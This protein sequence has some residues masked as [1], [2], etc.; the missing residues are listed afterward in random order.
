MNLPADAADILITKMRTRIFVE[1]KNLVKKDLGE[2]CSSLS[3]PSCHF[4]RVGGNTKK[5]SRETTLVGGVIPDHYISDSPG[6]DALAAAMPYDVWEFDPTSLPDLLLPPPVEKYE[7]KML[8]LKQQ[9]VGRRV[10]SGF[11]QGLPDGVVASWQG[12]WLVDDSYRAEKGTS[13]PT[14][15]RFS[16]PVLAR[17]IWIELDSPIPE[18]T[19]NVKGEKE[20]EKV[21]K[22]RRKQQ[23]AIVILRRGT[24]TVWSSR[25]LIGSTTVDVLSHGLFGHAPLSPVDEIVVL[26]RGAGV[27]V[28]AIELDEPG[29][30][31]V[32]LML[33][34]KMPVPE[35]GLVLKH[36]MVDSVLLRK[37]QLTSLHDAISG[38]YELEFG[39]STGGPLTVAETVLGDESKSIITSHLLKLLA[40]NDEIPLELRRE[41]EGRK[42]EVEELAH[43]VLTRVVSGGE[44]YTRSKPGDSTDDNTST[45]SVD[46]VDDEI[47]EVQIET[48][49]RDK[50]LQTVEDLLVAALMH[51]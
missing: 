28:V 14:Y 49:D 31:L 36:V 7:G 11:S 9:A 46:S 13:L 1:T 25:M 20:K 16:K 35:G 44:L 15:I 4:E 42:D 48:Y 29:H 5:I 8:D 45:E 51:M 30:V 26:S 22:K 2:V 12:R 21:G 38:G 3:G 32:P 17:K 50:R 18:E 39:N 41:L 40:A 19:I 37:E 24:E 33:L 6:F 47:E 43:R 23:A 27:R 34:T 10:P